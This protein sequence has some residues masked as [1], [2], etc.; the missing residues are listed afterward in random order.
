MDLNVQ[1]FPP[2]V[3]GYLRVPL[4][5]LPSLYKKL[6]RITVLLAFLST[7]VTET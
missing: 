1:A 6:F 5:M 4:V 2:G 3:T 7:V